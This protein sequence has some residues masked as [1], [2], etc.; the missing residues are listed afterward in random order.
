M[1]AIKYLFLCFLFLPAKTVFSQNTILSP[2]TFKHYIDSFNADD[3][4]LYKQYYSNEDAWKFLKENIPFFE[5]PDKELEK[6]YYFRWWTF[7][8]HI[9]KTPEGFVITEFLPDVS[10][11]GKYN[12]ISCA[13]GHHFYEGRWLHDPVYLNDYMNFWLYESGDAI[14]K[15]SFWAADAWKAFLSVHPEKKTLNSILDKLVHNYYKWEETH[16]ENKSP[17]FWQADGAD[18][19]E[20]SAGGQWANNGIPTPS[21]KA[22]RPTINSYM[23][24]DAVAIAAMAKMAGRSDLADTFTSKA[25][26]IKSAMMHS[27]WS[28]SLKFFGSIPL[29]NKNT[30]ILPVR[31]LIGFVPWYFNMPDDDTTYANAWKQLEN[32][33]GFMAKWGPTTCEQRNL[34]FSISYEGHECQWN[35]PS[36]PYA[37]SQ[38]LTAMAN[39]LDNYT[40]KPVTG[41]DYFSLLSAYSNSQRRKLENGKVIP[42][43]DENINPYTGDWISRTRLKNWVGGPWPKNKGGKERGKDYNHS[44][45]C[46]LIISGLIGLRTS[47]KDTLTINPL[48]TAD[49]WDYFCLDNVLYQN[50]IITVLYDKT[51]KKYNRGKGFK[52]FVNGK[53]IYSSRLINKVSI[54]I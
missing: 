18:G 49:K 2:Q 9:K 25:I 23:Y 31:E 21:Y 15:Y 39:L 43:I 35:G 22:L 54:P 53:L 52:I 11:A 33:R 29:Q 28:D 30:N 44:T 8:K 48:L 4:E 1:T 38:T 37:T 36:W 10:W 17:L 12:T 46:D 19:M 26:I 32:H 16:R 27:L 5:C 20:V 40:C 14:R 24:G 45:F 3:N 50:K 13:A 51:G 6:T 34:Y 41:D 7:R 47:L 42:W